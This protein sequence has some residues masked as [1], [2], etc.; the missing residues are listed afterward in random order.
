MMVM[1]SGNDLF[2][3]F[4]GLELMALSSYV[5]VGFLHHDL[6][7]NEAAMKYF[8]VGAFGSAFF[9]YGI[10]LFGESRNFAKLFA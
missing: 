8:L 7:S 4:V 3:I 6:R 5:L 10:T 2:M 9:L 1:A